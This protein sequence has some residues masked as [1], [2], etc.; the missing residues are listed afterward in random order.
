MIYH[1][2]YEHDE[3]DEHDE[4]DEHD[5]HDEHDEPD[6]PDEHDEHDEPDEP[7]EPDGNDCGFSKKNYWAPPYFGRSQS[8]KFIKSIINEECLCKG[9]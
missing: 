2:V 4:P 1:D 8:V 3:H 6:E 7:D 9:V 5:E